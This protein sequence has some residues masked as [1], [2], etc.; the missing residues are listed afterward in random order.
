[1]AFWALVL[2]P[3]TTLLSAT[4]AMRAALV[5]LRSA[6]TPMTLVERLPTFD[7]FLDVIG[8]PELRTLESRFGLP[9]PDER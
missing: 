2:M 9:T 8:L 7:E 5:E 1:M 4:Q 6:G 3:L